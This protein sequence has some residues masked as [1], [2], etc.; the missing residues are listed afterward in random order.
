MNAHIPTRTADAVAI[1]PRPA[2]SRRTHGHL[3]SLLPG[4]LL[5]ALLAAS[6]F[7]FRLLPGLSAFSPMIIAIVIG[8]AFHNLVGTPALAKPGVAFS[9]RKVLRFAIILLGLQ[10]TAAQVA[11]VGATGIAIIAATLLATFAFTLWLGKLIGVDRKLSELIAAGTSICGAS[12]VIATNTVTQAPD[13]D[14]AYAVACVTV[15]GSIAM[16]A[17]PLLAGMFHLAP[18]AY[19]LWAG[20]SIHEIAQVVAAAFQGGQQSGEFGTVAK[21]T[22]VMMLAPM[23]IALGLAARQR[24]KSTGSEHNGASAPMPWFVLGFVAMVGLNSLIDIPAEAKALIV[25]LTT[26]L[27]TMAL[28]AMGLETDIRKLWARGARPLILGFGA[29]LFIATFSL[30]LVK[31][32]G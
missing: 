16:F 14:V 19:G 27:L 3:R 4:L 20:A 11:A 7:A 1:G 25:T 18:Q 12:A 32:L 5:V 22:R 8:M 28:A 26:F 30:M 2:V 10:L 31:L 23:V 17:Y 15:F 29:F 24:A 9:M 6:A 21:L 13:E